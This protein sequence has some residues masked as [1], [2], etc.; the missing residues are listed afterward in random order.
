MPNVPLDQAVAFRAAVWSLVDSGDAAAW[1]GN[2]RQIDFVQQLAGRGAITSTHLGLLFSAIDPAWR[3]GLGW[4]AVDLPLL[5]AIAVRAEVRLLIEK[6]DAAA[7]RGNGR[8]ID[9]VQQLA[10]QG[11]ITS[12]TRSLVRRS[13][14]RVADGLGM[15]A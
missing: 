7:W 1:R 13:R 2:G 10:A 14:S 8:Q 15:D 9:F 3:A 5:Q 4:T 11:T 12:T 6:G